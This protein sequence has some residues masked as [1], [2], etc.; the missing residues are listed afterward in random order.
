MNIKNLI[1]KQEIQLLIFVL[2]FSTM[3]TII[4]PAFLTL[5]NL[6]DLLRGSSG[7]AILAIGIF[8]VLL[9][10][11]IDVSSTTIAIAGQYI[12]INVMMAMGVNNIWFAFAISISVGISLGAINAIFISIL[13]LPTL[14]VT[15]GT[16]SLFHGA[17]LEFVGTRSINSG[18]LPRAIKEFGKYKILVLER[19]NGSE[20]GL[21]V[22][23]LIMVLVVILTWLILRYTMIGRGIYAIGG[24]QDA[25]ERVGFKV[26]KIKLFVYCYAGFLAGIMG[27]MHVALIRSANPQYLVG[28]ELSIIAAVV[29]GGTRISGGVGTISGTMIGVILITVLEKN[30]VLLGLSSYWQKFFV[31]LIIVMGVIITYGD[32]SRKKRDENSSAKAIEP[33]S[34]VNSASQVNKGDVL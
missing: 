11:G 22:F 24:N 12:A 25:A 30:L 23:F 1:K 8:L 17:L 7:V 20:Y 14:I 33:S 9:S 27:V 4:S 2:I 5:E 19:A 28:S 29:L 13:N 31:G 16:S 15:L 6:F 3:I 21:S 10:G 34:Q 32:L 26:K 18:N